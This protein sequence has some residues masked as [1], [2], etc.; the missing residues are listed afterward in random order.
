METSP[1][2]KQILQIKL[3]LPISQTSP[4]G[5]SSVYRLIYLL[6]LA[7]SASKKRSNP[8]LTYSERRLHN[9]LSEAKQLVYLLEK[10]QLVRS[11]TE[12]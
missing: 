11:R 4:N 6:E 9:R 1:S 3:S 8:N 5:P 10:V 12:A 7:Y 2:H